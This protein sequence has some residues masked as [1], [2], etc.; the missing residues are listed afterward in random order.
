M[1]EERRR[2]EEQKARQREIEDRRELEEDEKRQALAAQTEAN[3]AEVNIHDTWAG[4]EQEADPE[5]AGGEQEPD[6]GE[7]G[8]D[9]DPGLSPEEIAAQIAMLQKQLTRVSAKRAKTAS[10]EPLEGRG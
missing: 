3:P 2:Q 9:D 1:G 8:D 4:V 7:D 5:I 10:V 6:P